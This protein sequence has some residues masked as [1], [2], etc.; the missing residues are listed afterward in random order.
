MS[1]KPLKLAA[2]GGEYYAVKV[3]NFQPVFFAMYV[4]V[5]IN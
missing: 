4:D 2:W 1:S 3:I 5:E